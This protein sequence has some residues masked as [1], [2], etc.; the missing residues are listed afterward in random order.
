MISIYAFCKEIS[1]PKVLRH[2]VCVCVYVCVCVEA[3]NEEL[4]FVIFS[5]KLKC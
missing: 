2:S 3:V 1:G 4:K 5:K